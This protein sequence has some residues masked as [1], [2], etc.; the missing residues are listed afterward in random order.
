MI[1]YANPLPSTVCGFIDS[2]LIVSFIKFVQQIAFLC[3]VF[4]LHSQRSTCFKYPLTNLK[5]DFT[6]LITCTAFQMIH[7]LVCAPTGTSPVPVEPPPIV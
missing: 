6:N 1:F 5:A 4:A 7:M 3:L 2:V